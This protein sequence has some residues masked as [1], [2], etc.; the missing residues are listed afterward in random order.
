VNKLLVHPDWQGRG[1]GR[2]LMTEIEALARRE[3]RTLLHLDTEAGSPATAFY[4][5]LG[6]TEAGTIPRWAL[7][8]H[9][10]EPRGTTFYY[11]LLG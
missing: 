7:S 5:R 4:A 3:G 9:G 10:G 6:W 1:I 8:P 11:K 2:L